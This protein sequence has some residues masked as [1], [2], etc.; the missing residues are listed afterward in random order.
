MF[1]VQIGGYVGGWLRLSARWP[2]RRIPRTTRYR[3][4][5]RLVL[6]LAAGRHAVDHVRRGLGVV[7]ARRTKFLFSPGVTLNRT[8]VGDYGTLFGASM[9]FEWVMRGGTRF[10]F[11]VA[12]GRGLGGEETYE[13]VSPTATTCASGDVVTIDRDPGI[14]FMIGLNIGFGLGYPEPTSPSAK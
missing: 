13:C 11:E 6:L 1:G 2:C 14:F 8:D 7:V 12:F 9:P 5:R 10:G 4:R 3:R